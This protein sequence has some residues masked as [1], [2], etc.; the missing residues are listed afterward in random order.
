MVAIKYENS[1]KVRV[2]HLPNLKVPKVT[3]VAKFVLCASSIGLF[4]IDVALIL[5]GVEWS[6]V[7]HSVNVVGHFEGHIC[8]NIYP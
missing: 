3:T 2:V 4:V 8:C 6:V 1:K 5:L 7:I